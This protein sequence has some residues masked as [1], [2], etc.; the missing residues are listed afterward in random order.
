MSNFHTSIPTP[1]WLLF[2]CYEYSVGAMM[3]ILHPFSALHIIKH[4]QYLLA[5]NISQRTLDVLKWNSLTWIKVISLWMMA[6]L[7]AVEHDVQILLDWFSSV[8]FVIACGLETPLFA[9]HQNAPCRWIY[10]TRINKHKSRYCG[11]KTLKIMQGI[12]PMDLNATY[13]RLMTGRNEVAIF[14]IGLR[15]PV[16]GLY[17]FEFLQKRFRCTI[18]KRK[19]NT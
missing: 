15:C 9:L 14:A 11:D 19:S 4:L 16:Q 18:V 6:F 17:S 13:R 5:W 7:L 10:L 8:E 12:C 2:L 3:E 1:L